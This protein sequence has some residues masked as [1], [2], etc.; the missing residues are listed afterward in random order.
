MVTTNSNYLRFW[1]KKIANIE[2]D[3]NV[4]ITNGEDIFVDRNIDTSQLC[5]CNH[6]E[7]DTRIL[8]HVQHCKLLSVGDYLL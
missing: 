7:A 8:F 3:K 4:I 1:R 5:P 2:T 6:E